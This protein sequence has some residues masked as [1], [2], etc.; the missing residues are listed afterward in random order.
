MVHC[1]RKG[2]KTGDQKARPWIGPTKM[3]DPER[4]EKD[5]EIR[6]KKSIEN[7]ISVG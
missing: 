5:L 1:V 7:F 2:S 4:T 6:G 3:G